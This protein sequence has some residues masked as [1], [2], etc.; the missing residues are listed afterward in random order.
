MQRAPAGALCISINRSPVAEF[1]SAPV[2]GFPS[3][4]DSL[5]RE[6]FVGE[7]LALRAEQ[8]AISAAQI[9][10][11]E[12]DP[13]VVSEI[14]LSGVAVQVPIADVEIAAVNPAL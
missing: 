14:K 7:P 3:A 2:A 1:Y 10:D 12:R 4:V 11:P 9:I 13:V 6:L 8:R 5:L